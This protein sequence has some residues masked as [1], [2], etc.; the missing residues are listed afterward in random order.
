MNTTHLIRTLLNR[1]AVFVENPRLRHLI[2]TALTAAILAIAPSAKAAQKLWTGLASDMLWSTAGN[3]SPTEMPGVADNVIFTN[4]AATDFPFALGGSPNNYADSL[5]VS[6]SINSLGYM[7]S[8]CFHNT[9]IT[10]LSVLGTSTTSVA[11]TAD[12][13]IPY[14]F[15][16]GNNQWQDSLGVS[17]WASIIGNSL[18]VSNVNASFGVTQISSNS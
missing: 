12:D 17:V 8:V 14:V 16:V 4:D 7:N 2:A 13:G 11:T 15:F 5:F 10:N 3:W 1:K 6:P 18:T 9:Q